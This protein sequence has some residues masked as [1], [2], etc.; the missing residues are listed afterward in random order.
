MVR[1]V[2]GIACVVA[3]ILVAGCD[4]AA[5]REA[6]N[7]ESWIGAYVASQWFV[8]RQLVA[9]SKAEFPVASKNFI[10]Y[11]GDCRHRI[12]AY[13]DGQNAFGGT[14]RKR[15][16]AVVRYGDG[17]YRLESLDLE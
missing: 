1:L 8:K 16:T 14:L 10:R 5:E 12:E 13:V 7:C 3:L 9:P 2:V 6:K 15:Y 4:S 17:D 11:L